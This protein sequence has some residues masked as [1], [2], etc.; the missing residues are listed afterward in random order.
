MSRAAYYKALFIIGGVWNFILSVPFLL[1]SY[2]DRTLLSLFVVGIF[3]GATLMYYQVFLWFVIVFG[4]GYT[5]V[6]LDL[7]KNHGIVLLGAI[8]KI[9]A[10]ISFVAYYL[11]GDVPFSLAMIGIGDLIFAILF[12]EFLINYKKLA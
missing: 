1:L 2:F 3:T 11:S 4:I 8:A 12:I 5:I 6:G 10:F 7:D 9:L